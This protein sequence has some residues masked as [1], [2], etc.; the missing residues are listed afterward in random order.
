MKTRKGPMRITLSYDVSL[1]AVGDNIL[2]LDPTRGVV[3][4]FDGDE[5]AILLQLSRGEVVNLDSSQGLENLLHAGVVK[6]VGMLSRRKAV[7]LGAAAAG[8]TFVSLSLPT[9]AMA[10]SVGS[11]AFGF[12]VTQA[13]VETVD[14][15]TSLVAALVVTPPQSTTGLTFELSLAGPSSGFFPGT[16]TPPDDNG[17]V[18]LVFVIDSSPVVNNT[19]WIR[20]RR[21]ADNV[22]SEPREVSNVA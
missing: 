11:P 4:R 9:A 10:Q 13:S 2:V 8:A 17:L 21:T 12:F 22:V 1:Q 7:T 14:D 16:A 5:A 20:W 6:Q 19:V 15:K 3:E 18:T